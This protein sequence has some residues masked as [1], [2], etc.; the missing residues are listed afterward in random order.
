MKVW[1]T[2]HVGGLYGYH[3]GGYGGG[4]SGCYGGGHCDLFC[5]MSFL[6]CIMF[7]NYF[8]VCN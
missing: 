5:I 1:I 7:F 3:V 4:L 2:G 6:F 8:L